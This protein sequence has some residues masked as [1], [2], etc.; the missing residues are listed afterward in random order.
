LD[1]PSEY[2]HVCEDN[3]S[4]F[5]EKKEKSQ[6]TGIYKMSSSNSQPATTPAT[7]SPCE[8]LYRAFE[9][10]VAQKGYNECVFPQRKAFYDCLVQ[11]RKKNPMQRPDR[12][13]AARIDAVRGQAHNEPSK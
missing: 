13:F 9:A 4:T 2:R 12:G 6:P 11:E 10:C 1:K 5:L 3:S 8:E 7:P